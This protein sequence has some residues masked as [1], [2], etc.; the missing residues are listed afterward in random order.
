MSRIRTTR[1][2]K[3]A[4][5]IVLWARAWGRT[6]VPL[7]AI[8]KQYF[9]TLSSKREFA[10]YE[11]LLKERERNLSRSRRSRTE[12]AVRDFQRRLNRAYPLFE[13]EQDDPGEAP[14]TTP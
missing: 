14:E 13:K 5:R 8:R 6:D 10:M 2:A 7:K 4:R 12:E 3:D 11:A 1:Q 9:P